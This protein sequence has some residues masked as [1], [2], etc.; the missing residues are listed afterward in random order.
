[1]NES[2]KLPKPFFMLPLLLLIAL[3]TGLLDEAV[4]SSLND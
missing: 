1:M 4:I 2:M 3:A